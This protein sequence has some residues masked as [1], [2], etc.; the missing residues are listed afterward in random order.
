MAIS[1]CVCGGGAGTCFNFHSDGGGG[2][3]PWTPP[4]PLDPL[5][6]SPLSSSAAENLGFGNFFW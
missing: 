4:P 1:L 5:S 3:P 2:P 6:P